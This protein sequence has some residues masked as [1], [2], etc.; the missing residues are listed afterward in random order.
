MVPTTVI[1]VAYH[2]D[3]WIRR[4]IE[5]LRQASSERLRL[6]LVDNVGN[7]VLDDL[8]LSAFDAIRLT[9]E[10]PM[11]FA[12]ANNFALVNG[13]TQ[14]KYV[15]FLN[16]DTTSG[17]GWLDACIALMRERPDLGAVS[18]LLHTSDGESWDEGFRECARKSAELWRRLEDGEELD[19]WHEVPTITAAAMVVRTDL[20]REVGP[21]DPIY[22]S[23][24]EDYDLCRRITAA[25]KRIG[26]CT[27]AR[28]RHFGGSVS[29]DPE[30][31]RRRC[32]QLIR[33]RTIHRIRSAG[34]RR[35]P[36]VAGYLIRHFTYNLAR[37]LAG[38][39][40]AQ[41]LRE[42]VAAHF[43]LLAVAGRL[44]SERRDAQ[45]WRQYLDA[46]GWPETQHENAESAP[47]L[48]SAGR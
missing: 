16:Q 44:I 26:I 39:P 15:C 19:P 14:G 6:I 20:L 33:N 47:P 48:A 32:R 38:T 5:T 1:V 22:G 34:G 25:G 3:R 37:S 24:Y 45:V 43:D 11:G 28:V 17:D 35:L 23:Y 2:G 46:L 7:T 9:C 31:R 12:E 36:A 10:W 41:P 27:R 13:G 18:P 42:Y 21:F 4:C 29:V 40:S 30:A 8:D